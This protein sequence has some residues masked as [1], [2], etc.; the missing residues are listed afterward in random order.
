MYVCRILLYVCDIISVP[1]NATK[2]LISSFA[3]AINTQIKCSALSFCCLLFLLPAYAI[4]S[5]LMQMANTIV[6]M[7]LWTTVCRP[8]V[9]S[10]CRQSSL[11]L[12]LVVAI[13]AYYDDHTM[14]WIH[15]C[16]RATQD[17]S[18]QRHSKRDQQHTPWPTHQY[19]TAMISLNR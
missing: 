6:D 10:A 12:L 5:S 16:A 17:Q 4:I 15:G 9:L 7:P 2:A 18:H 8:T 1:V 19:Y 3:F 14:D 11:L 13:F